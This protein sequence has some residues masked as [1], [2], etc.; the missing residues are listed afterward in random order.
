MYKEAVDMSFGRNPSEFFI[1]IYNLGQNNP[2]YCFPNLKNN[3]NFRQF[4]Q[5][6]DNLSRCFQRFI[7]IANILP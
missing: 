2:E 3:A 5:E 1:E 6:N 7:Q 4:F